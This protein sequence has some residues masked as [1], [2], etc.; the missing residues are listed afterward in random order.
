MEVEYTPLLEQ[1]IRERYGL[2]D[3]PLTDAMIKAFLLNELASAI[4][5]EDPNA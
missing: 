4:Q 1:Q 2:V 5:K 3:G